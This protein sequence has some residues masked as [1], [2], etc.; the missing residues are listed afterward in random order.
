MHAG[1]LQ[2]GKTCSINM[3][4]QPVWPVIVQQDEVHDVV[5]IATYED[6]INDNTLCRFPYGEHDVLVDSQGAV[7][8]LEY[9]SANKTVNLIPDTQPMSMEDFSSLLRKHLCTM[10]ECCISKVSVTSYTDGFEMIRQ[11]LEDNQ[12]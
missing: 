1:Q 10:N 3:K 11:S 4:K 2:T 7:F 9:N 6:W 5:Y 12:F 8:R